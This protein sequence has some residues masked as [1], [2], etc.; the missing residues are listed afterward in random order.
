MTNDQDRGGVKISGFMTPVTNQSHE[1][2][3]DEGDSGTERYRERMR[4]RAEEVG[5]DPD[6][7]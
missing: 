1:Q 4:A 7:P 3:L 2:R 6:G 5:L